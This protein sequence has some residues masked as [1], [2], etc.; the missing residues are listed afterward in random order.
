MIK[1]VLTVYVPMTDDGKHL[2]DHCPI[3]NDN[4]HFCQFDLKTGHKGCPLKPLPQK[5]DTDHCEL[6]PVENWRIGWNACL[7]GIEK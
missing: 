1:C 2:C 4:L 7:E 6:F 3:W 5:L